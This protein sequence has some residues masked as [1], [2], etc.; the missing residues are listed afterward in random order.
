[1]AVLGSH[2]VSMSKIS[3]EQPLI[4]IRMDRIDSTTTAKG[5]WQMVYSTAQTENLREELE[6]LLMGLDEY[7]QGKKI[8]DSLR[9]LP[10]VAQVGYLASVWTVFDCGF[11]PAE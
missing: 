1:M 5:P 4:A 11:I 6:T 7:V 3:V 8:G 2:A 10:R 9:I